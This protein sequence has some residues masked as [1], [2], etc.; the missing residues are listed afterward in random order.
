LNRYASPQN[1]FDSG[2]KAKKDAEMRLTLT[3]EQEAKLKRKADRLGKP[4]DVVL[5]ELLEEQ[6]PQV[7]T[8]RQLLAL[9]KEERARILQAQAERAAV[10]YEKDLD[11]PIAERELTAFTALDGEEFYAYPK[12]GN[13]DA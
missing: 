12:E 5:D 8:A 1:A 3:Y 4:V 6:E 10:E 7:P 9:P 13:P 2:Q 11:R